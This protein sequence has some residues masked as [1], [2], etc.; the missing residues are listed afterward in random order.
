MR[1]ID[2]MSAPVHTIGAEES[3]TAAWEA[4]RLYRTHHLVVTGD[5]GRVTGVVSAVS[6]GADGNAE[7]IAPGFAVGEMRRFA[8]FSR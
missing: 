4:M 5:E 8:I 7:M 1:V 6:G 3:A 2:I